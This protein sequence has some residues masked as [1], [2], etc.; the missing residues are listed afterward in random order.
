MKIT[1][2]SVTASDLQAQGFGFNQTRIDGVFNVNMSLFPGIVAV[3]YDS[4]NE[5][6]PTELDFDGVRSSTMSDSILASTVV[7]ETNCYTNRATSRTCF[8]NEIAPQDAFISAKRTQDFESAIINKRVNKTTLK[9][10]IQRSLFDQKT[11]DP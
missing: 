2:L 1:A 5:P 4:E 6:I 9:M 11:L 10:V 3:F 7:L 8:Q